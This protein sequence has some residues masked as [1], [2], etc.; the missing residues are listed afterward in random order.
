MTFKPYGDKIIVRK[1]LEQY[2]GLIQIPDT[3]RQSPPVEGEVVAYGPD[4]DFVKA[5]DRIIFG[6]YAAHDL[7]EEDFIGDD[8]A[9]IMEADIIYKKE[10]DAI[11]C[12]KNS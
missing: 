1:V 12:Q 5:G 11:T 9:V 6:K 3:A 8:L 4:V 10:G 2:T 7:N